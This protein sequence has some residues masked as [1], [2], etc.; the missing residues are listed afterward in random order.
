VLDAEHARFIDHDVIEMLGEFRL[1]AMER[2]RV[3]E[4]KGLALSQIQ[5][6]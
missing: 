6:R 5:S 4:V 3:V 1:A 2:G